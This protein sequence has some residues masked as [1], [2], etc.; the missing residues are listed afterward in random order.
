MPPLMGRS[1]QR[2]K[3]LPKVTKAHRGMIHIPSKRASKLVGR[4]NK[5][6]LKRNLRLQ[7]RFKDK[8]PTAE[9]QKRLG[10][11]E[12]QRNQ[13]RMAKLRNL[14]GRGRKTKDL[15][16]HDPLP[17]VQKRLPTGSL[18][19]N[20]LTDA[21]KKKLLN[22]LSLKNYSGAIKK[23]L[24]AKDRA[25]KEYGV[26]TPMPIPTQA[27]KGGLIGHTDYRKTGMFYGG[28]VKKKM[29]TKKGI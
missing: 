18:Y 14:E 7:E 17:M 12:I 8:P 1:R 22:E 19:D 29:I 10:L 27:N 2:G 11:R 20:S 28:M 24:T 26:L 25:K 3:V 13:K 4:F 6:D 9:Q 15:S 23:G 16:R 5:Q 21:Q